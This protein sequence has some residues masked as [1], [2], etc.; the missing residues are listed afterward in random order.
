MKPSVG[1]SVDDFSGSGMENTEESENGYGDT[2]SDD[3]DFVPV[4][5]TTVRVNF[6][7]SYFVDMEPPDEVP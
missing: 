1:D 7:C 4:S 6:G 2:F 3:E 5:L